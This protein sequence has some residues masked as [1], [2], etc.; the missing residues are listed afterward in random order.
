MPRATVCFEFIC[1]RFP[2]DQ[3]VVLG[4]DGVW[5][6]VNEF[7][8]VA[9]VREAQQ[10]ARDSGELSPRK[11]AVSDEYSDSDSFSDSDDETMQ[12]GPPAWNAALAAKK[13]CSVAR[14]RWK[15]QK[16][17]IDDITAVIVNLA[18]ILAPPGAS[19]DSFS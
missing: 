2:R 7:D 10:T 16:S 4:S 1:K 11:S 9:L 5:D 8:I 6:T 12:C 19:H 14:Q 15:Q 17:R 18:A 3:F 13:L